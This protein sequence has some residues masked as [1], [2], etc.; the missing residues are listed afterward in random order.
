MKVLSG[1]VLGA[2]CLLAATM[3]TTGPA[4]SQTVPAPAIAVV[5]VDG[6]LQQ[7]TAAKSARTQIERF[8]QNFRDEVSREEAA[9]RNRQQEL[10]KAS[11]T[12]T[13][14][15]MAEKARDFDASVAEFRRK[16]ELRSR[17]LDKAFGTAM[18]QINDSMIEVVRAA[19]S[20]HG[21]NLVLPRTQVMLYD[22]SINITREVA[23]GL[24]Q[25]LP[26]V[27]VPAPRIEDPAAP[28][29]SSKKKQ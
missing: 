20:V 23:D 18:S 25:K 5:D 3:A 22:E 4:F 11:K 17:A 9:L 6:V 26:N 21:A 8:Q 28:A 15:Q 14:E 13:P 29:A 7:S 24:N 16:A 19:A 10:Q 12:L 2:G 27:T 1:I